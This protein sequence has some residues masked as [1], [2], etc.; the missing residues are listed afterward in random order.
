MEGD[1]H[2]DH[3]V[4]I[5]FVVVD[6]RT[7]PVQSEKKVHF[8]VEIAQMSQDMVAQLIAVGLTSSHKTAFEIPGHNL[9]DGNHHAAEEVKKTKREV[10]CGGIHAK[11]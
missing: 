7:D 8:L 9:V 2:S 11:K 1:L 10:E 6:K 3:R 4:A 5:L